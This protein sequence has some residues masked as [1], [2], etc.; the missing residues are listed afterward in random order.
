LNYTGSDRKSAASE[1]GEFDVLLTTYATMRIDV[2]RLSQIGFD[3]AI[4]DESQAIKNSSALVAKASRLLRTTLASCGRCL[5][6]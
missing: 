1:F 5:S 4:L 2:Q 6:F 3:Y